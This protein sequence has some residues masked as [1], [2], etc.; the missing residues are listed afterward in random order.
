MPGSDAGECA[1]PFLFAGLGV[2]GPIEEL[3]AV[4]ER[5]RRMYQNLGEEANALRVARAHEL[6]LSKL[7][8]A[9]RKAPAK[10]EVPQAGSAPGLPAEAPCKE[11]SPA[12]SG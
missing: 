1:E 2:A 10:V 12:G 3:R 7:E 8:A 11:D 4:A 6:A 9:L 5:K